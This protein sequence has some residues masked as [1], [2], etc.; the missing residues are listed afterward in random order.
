MTGT[1]SQIEW[2]ELIKPRVQAEFDR[3]A[4]AFAAVAGNQSD[5]DR[6]DTLAVIALVKEMC[7]AVMANPSAGYF[8]RNW[9]ELNDQVRQ[10]IFDD[11]RYQ[12]IKARKAARKP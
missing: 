7:A 2:A 11:A 1:P 9:R 3:V 12:T 10:M 8:I 6:R 5:E 4:K